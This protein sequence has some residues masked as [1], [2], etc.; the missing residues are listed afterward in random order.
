MMKQIAL[1]LIVGIMVAHPGYA[2]SRWDK[3]FGFE[4][5]PKTAKQM[6]WMENHPYKVV[7]GISDSCAK[8]DKFNCKWLRKMFKNAEFMRRL[9]DDALRNKDKNVAIK[10]FQLSCDGGVQYACDQLNKLK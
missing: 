2:A 3:Y 10:A 8:G 5:D 4:L 6:E 1:A 7:M 9:G